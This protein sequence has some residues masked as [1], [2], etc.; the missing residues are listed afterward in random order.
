MNWTIDSY[1]RLT[2]R[3]D[4]WFP[5]VFFSCI[6]LTVLLIL[7]QGYNSVSGANAAEAKKQ[8]IKW[9]NELSLAPS[10]ISCSSIDSDN[11]GYYSCTL[12]FKSDSGIQLKTVECAG[13]LTIGE[14]CRE[15]RFLINNSPNTFN[16]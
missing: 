13:A 10:S 4:S 6:A 1:G 3:N 8:A 11:N 16:Q 5:W 12:S 15:P 14:G 7:L 2:T 9:S